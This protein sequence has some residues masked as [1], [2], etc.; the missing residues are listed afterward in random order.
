MAGRRLF[1]QYGPVCYRIS[2]WKE[3]LLKSLADRRSGFRAAELRQEESLPVIVKSHRSPVLRRLEGS[4]GAG[5]CA[6]ILL[7]AGLGL[8]LAAAGAAPAAAALLAA[9]MALG[10]HALALGRLGGDALPWYGVVIL[11]AV[12][13]L[14]FSILPPTGRLFAEQ[15]GVPAASIPF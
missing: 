14:L 3:G 12:V 11:L 10:V 6:A 4:G 8:A 1:C 15:A 9:A 7:G 13:Y 2:L 5:L